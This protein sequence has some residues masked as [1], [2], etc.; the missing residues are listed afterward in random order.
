MKE[1]GFDNIFE[2]IKWMELLKF[3]FDWLYNINLYFITYF[4]SV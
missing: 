1:L 4:Y 2:D 3:I